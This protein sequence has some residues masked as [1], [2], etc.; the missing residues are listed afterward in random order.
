ML[1]LQLLDNVEN[2]RKNQCTKNHFSALQ[3]VSERIKYTENGFA[4]NEKTE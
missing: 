4:I 1:F 2:G 3:T